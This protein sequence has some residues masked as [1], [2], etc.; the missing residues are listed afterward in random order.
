MK[1][2][3]IVLASVLLIACGESSTPSAGTSTAG[4]AGADGAQ[5]AKGDVGAAGPAGAKGDKGDPG[6]P[7]A[8]G[9]A[10][11]A[12]ATGP[13][14]PSGAQG[15]QGAMGPQGPAGPMGAQGPVGPE[16]PAI[17]LANT[18]VRQTAWSQAAAGGAAAYAQCNAGDLVVGGYCEFDY[19]SDGRVGIIGVRVDNAG[20]WGQYCSFKGTSGLVK[21]YVTCHVQ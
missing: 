1:R 14:G 13:A 12:G 18:Y 9:A 2:H 11:A 5:G 8:Q 21:A 3:M 7:G 10:G 20:K 19:G 6:G 17:D 16:G 4:A 15:P